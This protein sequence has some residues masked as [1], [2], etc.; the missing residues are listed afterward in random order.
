MKPILVS[1]AA[2]G[3]IIAGSALAVEMPAVGK[4]KCGACHSV[5]KKVVGPAFLDV[6]AKYKGDKEAASKIAANITKGGAFGWKLG[7]MPAKG[8]GGAA[9][10]ADIK[11]MSEFIAGLA[12]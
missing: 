7:T 1:M 10:D 2:A 5:D 8:L 6:A 9:S 3:L 12:K 4:A 11:T